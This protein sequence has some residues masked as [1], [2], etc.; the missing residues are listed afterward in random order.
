MKKTL[1]PVLFVAVAA[2]V[3]AQQIPSINLPDLDGNTFN[4]SK[5]NN[6]NGVPVVLSFWATWCIP[7]I[8]E[9]SVINDK[10]QSWKEKAQFEFYAISVDDS[11]TNKRVQPL[12]NGKDWGFTVLLD[13]NQDLKRGLNLANIPYT[14][15]IKDG[16]IIYRHAGYVDGDEEVLF[17]IINQ[18]Q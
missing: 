16:K 11:R 5:L 15:V 8:N 1:L 18:N 2:F 9:L 17:K 10:Y 7:C 4:T 12:V 3:S 6:T 13:K 14:L